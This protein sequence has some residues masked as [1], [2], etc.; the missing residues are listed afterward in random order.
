MG[1]RLILHVSPLHSLLILRLFILNS[2]LFT[3]FLTS[4]VLQQYI[5]EYCIGTHY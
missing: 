5:A 2:V 1:T 4:T 3:R